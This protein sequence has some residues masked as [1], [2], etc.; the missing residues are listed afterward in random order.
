MIDFLVATKAREASPE[1]VKLAG[2]E[3]ADADVR[4][5]AKRAIDL[6]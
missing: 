2:D 4:D 5:S 6:L 1:L 3:K